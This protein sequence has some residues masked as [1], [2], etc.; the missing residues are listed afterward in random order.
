MTFQNTPLWIKN[1]I[2]RDMRPLRQVALRKELW[3]IYR[4]LTPE[5]KEMTSPEPRR[6]VPLYQS[7]EEPTSSNIDWDKLQDFKNH[8]RG[9][10]SFQNHKLVK[11]RTF[12][13]K[14]ERNSQH[15]FITEEDW[16]TLKEL[17]RMELYK[18]P[19]KTAILIDERL[20]AL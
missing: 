3:K 9:L 8:Y 11:I 2:P 15:N 17:T 16:N 10:A 12:I 5:E 14:L 20:E 1:R 6:M 18:I 13:E 4:N 19:T 7:P